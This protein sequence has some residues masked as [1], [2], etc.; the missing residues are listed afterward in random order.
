MKD[1]KLQQ[2]LCVCKFSVLIIIINIII[3][4][5]LVRSGAIFFL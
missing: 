3:I 5:N 1:E 4:I 2:T